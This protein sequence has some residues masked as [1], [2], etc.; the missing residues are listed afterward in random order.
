MAALALIAGQLLTSPVGADRV[1]VLSIFD[2]G[3]VG[4]VVCEKLGGKG[5]DIGAWAIDK[6]CGWFG[7]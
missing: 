6:L 4:S 3:Y 5:Y 7:R 2:G 1:L